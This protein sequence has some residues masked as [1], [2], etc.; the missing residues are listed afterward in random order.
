[1]TKQRI[2]H[3]HQIVKVS[4]PSTDIFMAAHFAYCHIY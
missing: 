4:I 3:V 2:F 1:M